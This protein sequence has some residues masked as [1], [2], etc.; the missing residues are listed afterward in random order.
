[1]SKDNL[2]IFLTNLYFD[3]RIQ[4]YAWNHDQNQPGSL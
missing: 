1:M 4:V 2:F 3:M